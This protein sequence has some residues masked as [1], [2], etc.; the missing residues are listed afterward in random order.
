[1][2]AW[3]DS[4]C[5][6]SVKHVVDFNFHRVEDW[7]MGVGLCAR[8]EIDNDRERH[9]LDLAGMLVSWCLSSLLDQHFRF[10]V[11]T[12]VRLFWTEAESTMALRVPGSG[13][14]VES[15][16][17]V[18]LTRLSL[19]LRP[20]DWVVVFLFLVFF[21][22]NIWNEWWEMSGTIELFQLYLGF[23]ESRFW[24]SPFFNSSSS[25]SRF[26]SMSI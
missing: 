13:P 3:C 12:V 19:F 7:G 16:P 15:L 25:I 21:M 11:D 20:E 2:I 24:G 26:F 9:L 17:R 14:S 8:E 22:V 5:R 18:E 23:L 6:P 10:G 4:E 1:M